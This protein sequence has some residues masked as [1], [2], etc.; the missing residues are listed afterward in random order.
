MISIEEAIQRVEAAVRPLAHVGTVPLD[1]AVGE[2]L[3]SDV[4]ADVDVPPFPQ[5]RMDGFALAAA[6]VPALPGELEI[7]GESRAG[8]PPGGALRQGTAWRIMTGAPVPEGADTV[9][10]VEDTEEHDGRVRLLA[11][12]ELAQANITP[13]GRVQRVG[14]VALAKGARL[15]VADIAVLATC[16]VAS[17]PVRAPE[18]RALVLSGGDELVAVTES[19]RPGQ[20][21][22]SNGPTL[23][24]LFECLGMPTADSLAMRDTVAA[25]ADALADALEASDLVVTSG[26]VS[27]GDY[28]V[29]P[30][31]IEAVG[32]TLHFD[33]VAMQPGKPVTLAT[34]PA[35]KVI[36]ALPGNPCSAFVT[37]MVIGSAVIG[38]LLGLARQATGTDW[39]G[40]PYLGEIV[41]PLAPDT[42]T[43]RRTKRRRFVPA[44]LSPQGELQLLPWSG[45]ADLAGFARGTHLAI[46]EEGEG[47]LPA[48]AR[49]RALPMP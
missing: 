22:N 8:S 49:I 29:V 36:L 11:A 7:G 43:I 34:T 21:R 2:V 35:G 17:V 32:G 33:R 28:D 19:P 24:R 3:A 18:R 13:R 38:R 5:A 9:V 31:A 20:I 4:L 26:G 45:S 48:D 23:A 42:A 44:Q 37:A 40:S 27:M 10:R 14:S 30:E 47:D 1:E 15:S 6:D 12:A 41:A 46:L 39:R 16:G 25:H